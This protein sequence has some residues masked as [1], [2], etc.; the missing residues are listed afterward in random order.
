MQIEIGLDCTGV[1]G[2]GDAV[3][4]LA[5]LAQSGITVENLYPRAVACS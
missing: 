3:L 4:T 5:G 2:F 1:M